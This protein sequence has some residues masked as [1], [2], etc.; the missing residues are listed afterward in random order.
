[1]DLVLNGKEILEELR[2]LRQ[3]YEAQRARLDIMRQEL[4]LA[5]EEL[6]RLAAQNEELDALVRKRTNKLSS[7]SAERAAAL[8]EKLIK[9]G[10]ESAARQT[11]ALDALI[12]KRTNKLSSESAELGERLRRGQEETGAMLAGKSAELD[13]LIRKRS[14]QMISKCDERASELGD[15]V[16]NERRKLYKKQEELERLLRDGSAIRVLIL[17][18]RDASNLFIENIVR[19]FIRRGYELAIFADFEDSGSIRMFADMDVPIRPVSELTSELAD[20]YDFIFCPLQCLKDVLTFNRYV[21]TYYSMNPA[22]DPLRGSDFTFTWGEEAPGS[23]DGMYSLMPVGNPKNDTPPTGAAD[24]GRILFLDS[25]H[26]PFSDEGKTQV[27]RMLL[28]ICARFPDREVWVKPRWLPGTDLKTMT[29]PSATHL[30]DCVDRLCGGERPKNLTLLMEHLDLQE[31]IDSSHCVITT[32]TTAYLDAALRGKGQLIVRGFENEDVFDA[33][34][35]YFEDYYRLMEDTGC[36]VDVNDVCT[37]LPDGIICRP[38]HLQRTYCYTSGVSE[39]IV[40]VMED[41]CLRFLR[42]GTWPR[43]GKYDY[44]TFREEMKP[45]PMPSFAELRQR[46]MYCLLEGEP[47]QRRFISRDIDWDGF[48]SLQKKLLAEA[49]QDGAGYRVLRERVAEE[50]MKYILSHASE[51]GKSPID[52]SYLYMA[53]Y[54]QGKLDELLGLAETEPDST[55]LSYYCGL[56]HHDLGDWARGAEELSR[57]AADAG[58]RPFRKYNVE[59]D[60][61]RRCAAM[62]ALCE[63]LEHTGQLAELANEL[64]ELCGSSAVAELGETELRR[65]LALL[66]AAREAHE[67][68]PVLEDMELRLSHMLEGER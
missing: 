8:E 16:R 24:S 56:A 11:E 58:S 43:A 18:K 52:R 34:D 35:W 55:A 66:R 25:G 38:E 60:N 26:F 7:E 67:P 62:L 4:G 13:A 2:A 59:T 5:R 44:E 31:L 10:E 41:I 46:R 12:R 3:E 36:V 51:L 57:F 20:M 30:Y 53:L 54:S 68:S 21:F 39:R 33:R 42:K 1:M 61:A 9:S 15:L 23:F 32:C 64:T 17:V 19:E 47:P 6:A 27:A 50:K 48:A 40:S 28:D 37:H 49:A 45:E 63:C 14:N 65:L 29:H 22:I